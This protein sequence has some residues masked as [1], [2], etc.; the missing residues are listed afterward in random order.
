MHII[1]R[2]ALKDFWGKYPDSE[3]PLKT[4][5][6]IVKG[7]KYKS[8]NHLRETFRTADKVNDLVV[9][10]IGGNKYRLAAV[11]HFPYGKV[12]IRRI[13]THQEYNR[14]GWKHD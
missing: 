8:F 3:T 5:F 9:F 11:I 14:E 4:W 13:M 2:K 10:N 6:K 7:T 1:S 12:Y